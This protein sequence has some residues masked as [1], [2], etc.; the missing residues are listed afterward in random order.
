MLAVVESIHK[1]PD[2]LGYQL[3]G[4]FLVVALVQIIIDTHGADLVAHTRIAHELAGLFRVDTVRAQV[5]H[6]HRIRSLDGREIE[7]DHIGIA[8]LGFGELKI[9]PQSAKPTGIKVKVIDGVEDLVVDKMTLAGQ[10]RIV[11][12]IIRLM[13]EDVKQPGLSGWCIVGMINVNAFV[14]HR[15]VDGLSQKFVGFIL[16][17]A[18]VL[19]SP[20]DDRDDALCQEEL[21]HHLQVLCG[22]FR[23]LTQQHFTGVDK[24]EVV[25]R[26]DQAVK[27]FP[28][29]VQLVAASCRIAAALFID[30]DDGNVF[31]V[32]IGG[33][34]GVDV[35]TATHL[36]RAAGD[37]QQTFST[38]RGKQLV[39]HVLRRCL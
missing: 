15:Q 33:L 19:T 20:D 9:V 36:Q 29:S 34:A 24:T 21:H 23:C 12:E 35:H 5:Q 25:M 10:C 8:E 7:A 11:E 31:L 37:V 2:H 4:Q 6:T 26:I 16:T 38:H 22:F 3:C 14:Y 18:Q 13:A 30:R 17:D 1:I 32:G 39:D 28:D 27:M